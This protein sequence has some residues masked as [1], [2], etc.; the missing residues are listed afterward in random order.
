MANEDASEGIMSEAGTMKGRRVLIV[1]ASSG[2]GASFAKAAAREGADVTIS[3]RRTER[4][5][6]LVEEM[7]TG[8][9]VSGDAIV[10][11]DAKRVAQT[12]SDAMGGIDLMFHRAFQL[13]LICFLYN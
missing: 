13:H 6:A 1:G 8:T 12:A 4:L 2:L 5:V 7:G 10:P 3:A 9:A 11:A